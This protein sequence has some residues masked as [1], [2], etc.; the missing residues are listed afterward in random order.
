M[1]FLVVAVKQQGAILWEVA[2]LNI[3]VEL[4]V[5]TTIQCLIANMVVHKNILLGVPFLNN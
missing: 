5:Q 4:V 1:E 3:G 2:F